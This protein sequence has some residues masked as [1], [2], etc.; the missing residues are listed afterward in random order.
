[1][2]QVPSDVAMLAWERDGQRIGLV[3]WR[4]GPNVNAPTESSPGK[5]PRLI[6]R[7]RP[8]RADRGVAQP[9]DLAARQPHHQRRDFRSHRAGRYNRHRRTPRMPLAAQNFGPAPT[10]TPLGTPPA[11]SSFPRKHRHLETPTPL[12]PEMRCPTLCRLAATGANTDLDRAPCG[13][14]LIHQMPAAATASDHETQ[15]RGEHPRPSQ[16]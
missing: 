1:M 5:P 6:I 13:T 7:S 8:Y 3:E 15:H 11:P 10:T 2:L 4:G 14:R 16:L 9:D 12:R